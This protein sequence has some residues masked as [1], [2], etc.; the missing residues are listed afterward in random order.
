VIGCFIAAAPLQKKV[1]LARAPPHP[2][3]LAAFAIAIEAWWTSWWTIFRELVDLVVL[4]ILDARS[5][6]LNAASEFFLVRFERRVD[7]NSFVRLPL[8]APEE[9]PGFAG[10]FCW[11]GLH[12][13]EGRAILFSREI[14][15]CYELIDAEAKMEQMHTQADEPT[16]ELGR[17]VLQFGCMWGFLEH[18][19]KLGPTQAFWDVNFRLKLALEKPGVRALGEGVLASFISVHPRTS[20]RRTMAQFIEAF[21]R[22]ALASYNHD[23]QVIVAMTADID[24]LQGLPQFVALGIVATH[25]WV[26]LE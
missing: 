15:P 5:G 18:K 3:L 21:V 16:V 24:V 19:E 9:S 13:G 1:F 8:P 11:S 2:P 26:D 20:D 6:A 22:A 23:V 12:K 14:V 4:R 17:R 25:F 10:V 7:G